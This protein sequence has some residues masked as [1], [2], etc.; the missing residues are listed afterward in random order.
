MIE[1]FKKK[2]IGYLLNCIAV[3]LGIIALICY[4]VSGTDKSEMT[5]TFVEPMVYIPI[6]VG[7]LLNAVVFFYSNSLVKIFAFMAYF[8]SLALWGVTQAGYIVNVI[9][10]IDGNVF[11]FAYILTLICLIGAMVLSLLSNFKFKRTVKN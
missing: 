2:G 4:L 8:L 5:P 1:F 7:I 10:G 6:I 3:A 11:S 9:M